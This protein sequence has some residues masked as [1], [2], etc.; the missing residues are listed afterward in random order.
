MSS[1]QIPVHIYPDGRIEAE[2]IGI[3]GKASL[4]YIPILEQLLI[5]ETVD[6]DYTADQMSITLSLVPVALTLRIAM[7]G[8]NFRNWSESMQVQVPTSFA[9]EL[10]LIRTVR[11]AGYETDKW[12][13]LIKTHL[14]GE[15]LRLYWQQIDGRWYAIF[16]RADSRQKIDR[17]VA[18]MNQA[19]GRQVFSNTSTQASNLSEA[20]PHEGT[21]LDPASVAPSFPTNF[22]DGELL[23]RTLK[24]LGL[25]PM[26]RGEDITCQADSSILVFRQSG[27]SPFYVEVHHAPD[28]R[29]V[30]GH[31]SNIDD[32]YKRC[33]QALVYEH[34]KDRVDSRNMTV[35]GEEVQ[36]D[37]SIIVTLTIRS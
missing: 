36:D 19:A 3:K 11:K 24:D 22:R 14:D 29:N 37:N 15:Q 26:R 21:V 9:S 17:F 33:V 20:S 6:S 25:N 16:G 35:N 10:E 13:G 5:A 23:F 1:P 27:I 28:L 30:F 7:G 2:V 18:D 12:S 32:D 31:L 8:E 34:L 4:D